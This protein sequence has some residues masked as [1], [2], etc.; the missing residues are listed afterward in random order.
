MVGPIFEIFAC[1][2]LLLIGCAAGALTEFVKRCLDVV[3]TKDRRRSKPM[4]L[5]MY[6]TPVVIAVL[7]AT[8]VP[9]RPEA[10]IQYVTDYASGSWFEERSV[11]ALWGVPPGIG[12]SYIYMGVR[13]LYKRHK[14][15]E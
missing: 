5:V 2:Q 4:L 3:M 1:W 14:G 12:A 8:F 6:A 11:Y 13:K 7:L 10:L 15:L 9:L